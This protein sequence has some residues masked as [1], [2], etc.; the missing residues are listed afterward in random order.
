MPFVTIEE[1]LKLKVY[2]IE[3]THPLSQFPL[4]SILFILGYLF[5]LI[6]ISKVTRMFDYLVLFINNYVLVQDRH[7]GHTIR[8]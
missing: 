8:T 6:S 3:Q 4:S 5:N 1:T 7:T 2:R